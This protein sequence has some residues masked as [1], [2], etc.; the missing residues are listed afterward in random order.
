MAVVA[1]FDD[2]AAFTEWF[3]RT[4]ELASVANQVDVKRVE[5]SG[6]DNLVHNLVRAGVGAFL[7]NQPDASQDAKDVRVERKDL[8]A[9][10]EQQRAGDGLR[11]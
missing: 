10:G 1:I 4:A 6:R 2:R 3:A 5:L 7:R 11:A 9:A 8:F